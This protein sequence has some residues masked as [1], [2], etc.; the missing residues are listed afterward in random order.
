MTNLAGLIGDENVE[1]NFFEKIKESLVNL[2]INDCLA[3]IKKGIEDKIPAYDMIMSGLYEAMKVIGEKF[4]KREYFIAE[5]MFASK[6]VNDSIDLL[7]PHLKT[8]LKTFGVVLIG[9][10]SGDLH[11]IGKNIMATL[12]KTN[13]IEVHDLGV[14]VPIEK[15]V[16]KI[17]EIKPNIVGLSAL[18]A[19]SISSMR[20]TIQAIEKNELRDKV[21]IV[22]GGGAVSKT[23]AEQIN[24]DAY[25]YDAM[26]GLKIIREF[27][28]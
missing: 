10:V 16:E 11:D 5:L 24:A 3:L 23:I 28:D 6:I 1:N 18:M 12:L 25:A 4:E 14:D 2:Q 21:K 20:N 22:V 15:F 17:K 9:T 13:G 8:D 26:E 7:K 27:L 19:A